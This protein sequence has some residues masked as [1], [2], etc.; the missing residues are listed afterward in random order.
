MPEEGPPIEPGTQYVLWGEAVA[1]SVFRHPLTGKEI[2]LSEK[3]SPEARL[4]F[5]S[6]PEALPN[7]YSRGLFGEL[8]PDELEV[9]TFDPK[10]IQHHPETHPEQAGGENLKE[11]RTGIM[12]KIFGFKSPAKKTEI[13]SNDVPELRIG[14]AETERADEQKEIFWLNRLDAVR[15]LDAISHLDPVVFVFDDAAEGRPR[16]RVSD[17]DHSKHMT[18]KAFQTVLRLS[19]QQP[20]LFNKAVADAM[21]M[22]GVDLA[23]G[24]QYGALAQTISAEE[25]TKLY[26]LGFSGW[27]EERQKAIINAVGLLKHLAPAIYLHDAKSP[28]FRDVFMTVT[29]HHEKQLSANYSEDA[30]LR[31]SI[32]FMVESPHTG[33]PQLISKF[34]L[35]KSLLVAMVK[36]AAGEGDP[37]FVGD[38]Y[39]A[40]RKFDKQTKRVFSELFKKAG[41]DLDQEGGTIANTQSLVEELFPGGHKFMTKKDEAPIGS[42]EERTRLLTYML[43]TGMTKKQLAEAC[44]QLGLPK[45]RIFIGAEEYSIW[46]NVVLQERTFKSA[47]KTEKTKILP[48][49][50]LPGDVKKAI[51]LFNV[52]HLWHYRS[53]QRATTEALMKTMIACN[54]YDY[55]HGNIQAVNRDTFIDRT[56]PEV[57]EQLFKKAPAIPYVLTTLRDFATVWTEDELA[58]H[59]KDGAIEEHLVIGGLPPGEIVTK[60]GTFVRTQEGTA[61]PYY[62]VLRAKLD[63]A[64]GARAENPLSLPNRLDRAD[65]VLKRRLFKVVKLD[66]DVLHELVTLVERAPGSRDANLRALRLW[67]GD[68]QLGDTA[69]RNSLDAVFEA[70][71]GAK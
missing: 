33:L 21:N 53:P 10:S 59:I 19:L 11:I 23:D 54:L 71:E 16:W 67:T 64:T 43:A 32:E 51:L 65:K 4:R 49:A 52:L 22:Y 48:V 40:K 17:L 42:F 37:G 56:D 41:W 6:D 36:S 46:H 24:T 70:L 29:A 13:G 18:Y 27:S 34:R 66:E 8:F 45:D 55:E 3:D 68:I 2:P 30:Q 62:E 12:E 35:N 26:D 38:L 31:D 63:P 1:K 39:K 20:E 14:F 25:T 50:L 61:E 5:I 47:N 69:V 15:Q 60:P 57:F 44:D 7:E 9:G 28:G 58:A